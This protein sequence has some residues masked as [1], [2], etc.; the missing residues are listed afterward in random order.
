M[1]NTHIINFS[2]FFGGRYNGGWGQF[3]ET[4]DSAGG[5]YVAVY[6]RDGGLARCGP[7]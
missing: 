6:E 7:V 1:E 5:N 2:N 4:R 3:V